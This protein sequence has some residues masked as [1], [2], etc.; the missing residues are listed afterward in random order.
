VPAYRQIVNNEGPV[1]GFHTCGNF[2]AV[3]C[4]LLAAF[5]HIRRLEVSGWNDVRQLDRIIAPEVGFDI[6]VIN[7]LVLVGAEADQRAR[8]EPIAEVSRRRPVQ[9]CAQAMV[10]LNSYE[11]TIERMNRFI[12]LAREVLSG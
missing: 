7:T 10:K 11:E 9:L 3:V 12:T 2:E 4:D 1:T 6:G 5:P 8:L